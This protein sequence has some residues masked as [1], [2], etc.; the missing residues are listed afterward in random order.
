MGGASQAVFKQNLFTTEQDLQSTCS[1]S[2][3]RFLRLDLEL[4]CRRSRQPRHGTCTPSSLTLQTRTKCRLRILAPQFLFSTTCLV[5]APVSHC[6]IADIS[7]RFSV[8]R[9]SQNTALAGCCCAAVRSYAT[10][11]LLLSVSITSYCHT[12]SPP[13]TKG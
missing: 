9:A 3:K 6:H 11:N 5:S 13:A 12:F 4:S 7:C 2:L 1:S 8:H 10:T